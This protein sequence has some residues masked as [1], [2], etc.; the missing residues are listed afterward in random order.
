MSLAVRS[1]G[2]KIDTH[3]GNAEVSDNTD[4]LGLFLNPR[5]DGPLDFPPPDGGC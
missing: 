4:R 5:P 1:A 2:H 3:N